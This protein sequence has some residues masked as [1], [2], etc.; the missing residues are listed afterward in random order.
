MS[1]PT[2]KYVGDIAVRNYGYVMILL[3]VVSLVSFAI[4]NPSNLV[5]LKLCMVPAF[6]LSQRG[7][8]SIYRRPIFEH[9]V[10]VRAVEYVLLQSLIICLFLTAVLWKADTSF[11][12]MAAVLFGS[13]VV[14]GGLNLAIMYSSVRNIAKD[15]YLENSQHPEDA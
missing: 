12:Q 5:A 13:F 7:L 8:L 10:T 11:T 1:K 9:T 15:G 3:L 6:F 4:G 14:I 2:L